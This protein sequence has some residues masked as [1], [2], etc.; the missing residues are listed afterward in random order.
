MRWP[1]STKNISPRRRCAPPF[2]PP[3]DDLGRQYSATSAAATAT[4]PL[5]D[6]DQHYH[7]EARRI[8]LDYLSEPPGDAMSQA[9]RPSGRSRARDSSRSNAEQRAALLDRDIKECT[10]AQ[11]RWDAVWKDA[12][13]AESLIDP[14]RRD[15]YQAE[16]LTMI[17]INRESNR[18]LLDVAQVQ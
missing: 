17:T 1:K 18:M 11:P 7:S 2:G 3:R 8:I 14:T 9:N 15:Y 6:G 4:F 16:V 5:V 10:D 12:V 13:A